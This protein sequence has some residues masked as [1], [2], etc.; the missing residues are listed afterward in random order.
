MNIIGQC[1]D[2][3][4]RIPGRPAG[5]EYS[6]W[7][8]F[9]QPL[10]RL[11]SDFFHDGAPRSRRVV[12]FEVKG[13]GHAPPRAMGIVRVGGPLALW[14]RV[15]ESASGLLAP[16]ERVRVRVPARQIAA[17]NQRKRQSNAMDASLLI[18]VQSVFHPWP[19]ER[20][21][22]NAMDSSPARPHPGTCE[23]TQEFSVKFSW[24]A[25]SAEEAM[26]ILMFSSVNNGITEESHRRH[27]RCL[28]GL[29]TGRGLS[30]VS[31]PFASGMSWLRVTVPRRY[32]VAGS[33]RPVQSP[34]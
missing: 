1:R 27:N 9:G 10:N 16:R 25:F 22:S 14:E 24:G 6:D 5:R 7:M 23:N 29:S 15:R 26:A 34:S 18:R 8:R 2:L 13:D 17:A 12:R 20:G 21:G 19:R 28:H 30:P 32:R 4:A 3:S 33:V 31:L 11:H